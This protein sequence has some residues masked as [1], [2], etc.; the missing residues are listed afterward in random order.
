MPFSP[1]REACLR[2]RK[3]GRFGVWV[4]GQGEGDYNQAGLNIHIGKEFKRQHGHTGGLG[5]LV[6]KKTLDGDYHKGAEWWIHG[7][8]GWA[9][10]GTK[11]AKP[12][13]AQVREILR[14]GHKPRRP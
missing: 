10:A 9:N 6:R 14:T 7:I 3:N 8:Y 13:E 5:A 1:E 4:G 12:T 2:R 11:D